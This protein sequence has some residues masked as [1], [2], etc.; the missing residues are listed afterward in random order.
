MPKKIDQLIE[1]AELVEPEERQK[2]VVAM[3]ILK[4]KMKEDSVPQNLEQARDYATKL[5]QQALEEGSLPQ[6]NNDELVRTK[7]SKEHKEVIKE[8]VKQFDVVADIGN[9]ALGL[10]WSR[11]KKSTS[12]LELRTN[13]EMYI[14]IKD[15]I[16]QNDIQEYVD[17]ID[18]QDSEIRQLKEYKRI[19]E[20]LFKIV[21]E[22]DAEL[23]L[24]SDIENAKLS[25]MLTDEQVCKMFECS[26]RKL[27]VLREKYKLTIL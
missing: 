5:T 2:I 16:H 4:G 7:K 27:G 9:P 14:A 3:N 1:L 17:F 12:I 8:V 25:L 21:F 23:K 20:E 11:V 24:L 26:R 6:Y 10:A 15:S 18:E 13:L 22:D 19:Q